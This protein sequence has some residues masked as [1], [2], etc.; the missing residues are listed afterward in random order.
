[1]LTRVKNRLKFLL[2]RMILRG[3]HYRLPVDEGLLKRIVST[4]VSWSCW[5]RIPEGQPERLCRPH[6][7][8]AVFRRIDFV[9][10]FGRAAK[11]GPSEPA[12]SLRLVSWIHRPNNPDSG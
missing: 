2:E 8:G 6:L 4:A 3:T 7:V 11:H 10:G 9:N 5:R 1:M 12:D